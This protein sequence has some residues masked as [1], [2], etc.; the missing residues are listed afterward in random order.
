MQSVVQR[1]QIWIDLLGE[2]AGQEAEP[3]PCLDGRTGQDD[4][5]DLLGLQGLNTLCDCQ[6]GLACACRPDAEHD[7]VVVDCVH[8]ALLIQGLRANRTTSV[9]QDVCSEHLCRTCAAAQQGYAAIN[10]LLSQRLTR[11]QNR[12]HLADQGLSYADLLD[13]AGHLDLIAAHQDHYSR[14]CGFNQANV[15]IVDAQQRHHRLRCRNGD[16]SFSVRFSRQGA[17]AVTPVAM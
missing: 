12:Q 10:G 3:L 16:A 17:H 5:R 2:R 14:E 4:A 13:C 15:S 6:I 1:A 7:R 9:A 11:S 8:I